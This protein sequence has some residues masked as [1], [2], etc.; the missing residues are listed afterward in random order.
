MQRHPGTGLARVLLASVFVVMGAYRLWGAFRGVP[1]AGSTLTFS[2]IELVLG[3]LIAG[4]WKL[5]A[6]ATI[7]AVL[8][9]VD[10]VLSHRFWALTGQAQSAQLLHFMK[11]VGLIGGLVL[12]ALTAGSERRRSLL[13]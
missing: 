9:A 2:A 13:R 12:L 6:T 11:N 3:L 1:T 10:A 8:M 5:R 7:A 4:G